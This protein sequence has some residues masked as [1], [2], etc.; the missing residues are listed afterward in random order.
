MADGPR[1]EDLEA[2]ARHHRERL[3]LYR[4]KMYG[5]RPTTMTQLRKL[6]RTHQDAVVRLRRAR[7]RARVA[8]RD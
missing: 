7:Q 6:E 1:I 8:E 4:A 3:D 5:Q 2:E